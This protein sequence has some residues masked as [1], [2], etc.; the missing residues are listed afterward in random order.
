MDGIRNRI[1][2]AAEDLDDGPQLI[3][4]DTGDGG[5]VA[6]PGGAP[7]P[8]VVGAFHREGLEEGFGGPP[9]ALVAQ[10]PVDLVEVPGQGLVH[11]AD[12]LVVGQADLL[13]GMVRTPEVPGPPQGVL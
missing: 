12:G 13:L 2:R 4:G 3:G 5:Q 8:A 6:Q 9:A 11:A 10:L 7:H 1:V